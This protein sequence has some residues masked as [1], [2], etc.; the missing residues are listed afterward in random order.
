MIS[1]VWLSRLIVGGSFILSGFTKA[2]DPWGTIYK[3]EQYLAVWDWAQPRSL[4]LIFT[5]LLC[6]S[7]FLIGISLIMGMYR[8]SIPRVAFLFILFFLI[9]TG[10]I[11]IWSP[12]DDC[13]CFGDAIK[14]SNSATF[15]KN[16]V[17]TIL[18]IFLLKYNKR[19]SSI[20]STL[21]QWLVLASSLIYIGLVSIISYMIQPLID[22]RD[23]PIGT[24]ILN[25]DEGER[26]T[27]KLKYQKGEEVALFDSDNLPSSESGWEYIGR[28]IEENNNNLELI[29]EDENG[30]DITSEIITDNGGQLFIVIPELNRADISVTMHLNRINAVAQKYGIDVIALIGSADYNDINW[31]RD[32]GMASYPIYIAD[33]STLKNLSRG[34][35]SLVYLEDGKII[36]K[37]SMSIISNGNIQELENGNVSFEEFMNFNPTGIIKWLSR[38]YGIILIILLLLSLPEK[39][40]NIIKKGVRK[41]PTPNS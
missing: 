13:G 22:F 17:L 6:A 37:V 15:Y 19:G 4:I 7:E 31:W 10:Y 36:D 28:V 34:E 41:I 1:G 35:T 38:I 12:V 3:L 8:K 16:V 11:V 27:I 14:L 2:V 26:V 18:I 30:D 32:I 24:E 5:L 39:Y 25:Q 21:L 23:F 29:I 40:K 20:F 33:A 9:L